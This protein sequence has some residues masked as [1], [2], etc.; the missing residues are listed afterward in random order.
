MSKKVIFLLII[1]IW[2]TAF[3]AVSQINFLTSEQRFIKQA[4]EDVLY[5]IRQDYVL[6]D[7][8]SVNPNEYGLGGNDYFGRIYRLAVLSDNKL[9][10][11]ISI[12]TPWEFDE[13]YEEYRNNKALR[14]KL[15]KIAVRK[16][17]E[18]YFK[19]INLL[20]VQA[21]SYDTLLYKLSICNFSLK[22]SISGIKNIKEKKD[23][24]SWIIL[25]STKDDIKINDTCDIKLT[26]YRFPVKFTN[27]KLDAI[28]KEPTITKNLLGGIY[29]NEKISIGKIELFFT[30]ILNKRPLRWY[31]S[32]I[33]KNKSTTNANASIDSLNA[34]RSENNFAI[35]KFVHK[36]GFIL[37][38]LCNIKKDNSEQEYCTDE[39][40][41]VKIPVTE[42]KILISLNGKGAVCIKKGETKEVICKYSKGKF[43]PK[44][45]IKKCN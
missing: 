30:G 4:T 10:C 36:E 24:N 7:T 18:R 5:I 19:P 40:G 39:N 9:W 17:N 33:P 23:G 43:V 44:K 42:N 32:T 8:T 34:I 11:D 3:T 27:D 31:I 13:N 6:K 22:D 16:I 14:P 1:N 29:F 25:A 26:I 28:V 12:R 20:E 35:V 2:F 37:K 45:T 38:N 41:I 21:T 15:S